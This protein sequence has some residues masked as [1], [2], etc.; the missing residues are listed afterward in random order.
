MILSTVW[1]LPMPKEQLDKYYQIP[2]RIFKPLFYLL[3]KHQVKN[4]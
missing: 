1:L 2:Y 4:L 3:A